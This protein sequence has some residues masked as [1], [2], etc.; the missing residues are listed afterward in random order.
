M[1]GYESRERSFKIRGI[2]CLR[3]GALCENLEK[4]GRSFYAN[5]DP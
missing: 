3:F 5:G 1:R 2:N 4:R